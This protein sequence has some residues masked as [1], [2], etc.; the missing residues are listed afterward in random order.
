MI[1]LPE[2]LVA[3]STRTRATSICSPA[4]DDSAMCEFTNKSMAIIDNLFFLDIYIVS[5]PVV[6]HAMS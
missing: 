4:I 5:A 3:R 6:F 1:E 2:Y